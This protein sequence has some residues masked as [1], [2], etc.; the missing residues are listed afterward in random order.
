MTNKS[1]DRFNVIDG[2]AT[3]DPRRRRRAALDYPDADNVQ[4]L[5][6]PRCKSEDGEI[7]TETAVVYRGAVTDGRH[8]DLSCA[9]RGPYLI[10]TR[11]LM[12]GRAGMHGELGAIALWEP[13]IGFVTHHSD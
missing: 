6:C 3:P 12:L 13:G 10:C 4:D 11:C 8:V 1:P 9:T 7:S 2:G 5:H